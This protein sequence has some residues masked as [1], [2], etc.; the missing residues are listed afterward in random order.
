MWFH[1]DCLDEAEEGRRISGPL[2]Q[3]LN[4]LPIVRG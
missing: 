2:R 4:K 1:I 3:Q